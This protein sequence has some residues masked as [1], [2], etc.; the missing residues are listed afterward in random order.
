MTSQQDRRYDMC[1]L[2]PLLLMATLLAFG[3][4]A[5]AVTGHALAAGG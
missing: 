2:M 1:L 3:I 5:F 4:L